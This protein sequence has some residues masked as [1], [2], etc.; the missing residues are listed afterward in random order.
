VPT[1][2]QEWPLTFFFD[3]AHNLDAVTSDDNGFWTGFKIGKAAGKGDM[4]FTYTWARTETDAVPSVFSYSDFGRSGGT[5][6]M[7]HFL[8][9]EYV[10]LPRLTLIAKEHLVNFINRPA[11]FHNPTQSRL[12]LDAVLAF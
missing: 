12:Q 7:G 10:L 4:R 11:G 9:L 1:P 6:V 5:N 2:F 3:F 8:A